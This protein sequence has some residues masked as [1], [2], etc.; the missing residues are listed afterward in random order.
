MVDRCGLIVCTLQ[1]GKFFLTEWIV[2]VAVVSDSTICFFWM[3]KEV[4]FRFRCK[5]D[6]LSECLICGSG[7]GEEVRYHK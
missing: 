6:G 1:I 5:T 4:C 3:G 2:D 7:R